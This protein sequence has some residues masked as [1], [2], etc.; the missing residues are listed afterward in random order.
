MDF[1]HGISFRLHFQS[2]ELMM[3][4]K[5]LFQ[6]TIKKESNLE[7][8]EYV[9]ARVCVP[10]GAIELSVDFGSVQKIRDTRISS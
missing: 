8:D 7:C 4:L 5:W 3:N 10:H 9:P 2:T 1:P 6:K